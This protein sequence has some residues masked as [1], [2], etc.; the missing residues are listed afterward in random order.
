MILHES[1]VTELAFMTHPRLAELA[2]HAGMPDRL[3]S[4]LASWETPHGPIRASVD[5]KAHVSVS[6]PDDCLDH[7]PG[8]RPGWWPWGRWG[9]SLAYAGMLVDLAVRGVGPPCDGSESH[10]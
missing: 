10:P 9:G 7:L 4:H 3:A 1:T 2:S 5:G 8:R 6:F